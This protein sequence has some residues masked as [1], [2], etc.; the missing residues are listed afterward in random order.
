MGKY[1]E[2]AVEAT[3]HV[4][5]HGG[6]PKDAWKV[7]VRRKF[8][9]QKASQEKGCPRVAYLGLCSEGMAR[10]V[11]PSNYTRPSSLNSQYAVEAVR[12]ICSNPSL[13]TDKKELW[14]R[15]QKGNKKTENGQ[16][17]VVLSLWGKDLIIP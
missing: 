5:R 4:R 13:A 2:A 10:G 3:E 14:S 15:I 17:D 9:T 8:P 1:G 12:L 11:P 7:A 16:M 6:S